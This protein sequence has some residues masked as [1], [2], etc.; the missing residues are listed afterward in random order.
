MQRES[1]LQ[2][3][4]FCIKLELKSEKKIILVLLY[5][6]NSVALLLKM[7]LIRFAAIC[8][9]IHWSILFADLFFSFIYLF[10]FFFIHFIVRLSRRHKLTR[11]YPPPS[12]KLICTPLCLRSNRTGNHHF[13]RGSLINL[14]PQQSPLLKL[15]AVRLCMCMSTNSWTYWWNMVHSWFS[16]SGISLIW[17]SRFGIESMRGRWDSRITLE[18]MGLHEIS[19]SDYGTEEPY[20]K[21]SAK[22]GVLPTKN[23]GGSLTYHTSKSSNWRNK[24]DLFILS[25]VLLDKEKLKARLKKKTEVSDLICCDYV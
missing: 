14:V 15:F 1:I 20:W 17:S 18:I 2:T 13:L 16:G 8:L 3:R 19:G 24:A 25:G 6:L 12:Q 22:I 5:K 10:I 11:M 21:P 7:V 9:F 4:P 23:P